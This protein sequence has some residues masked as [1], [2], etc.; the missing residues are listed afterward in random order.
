[1][2]ER[3]VNMYI[4]GMDKE[5]SVTKYSNENYYHAEE[6]RLITHDGLQSGSLNSVKG[7]SIYFKIPEN[8]KIHGHGFIRN[9][10]VLFVIGENSGE[11]KI[12]YID[13]ENIELT[14][15]NYLNDEQLTINNP[16]LKFKGDLNFSTEHPI[17]STVGRY[18]TPDVQKVYWTDGY[19]NVRYANLADNIYSYNDAR[20]FDF[21]PDVTFNPV[22]L[23]S[24]GSGDLKNGVVQYAYQFYNV[25]GSESTFSPA[26]NMIDLS[27][28]SITN[29]NSRLYKGGDIGESSGKSVSIIIDVNT[30]EREKFDRIR[31]VRIHHEDINLLPIIDIVSEQSLRETVLFTDNGG[32]SLETIPVEFFRETLNLFKA[33]D[34]AVKNNYLFAG[35]IQEDYFD[36]EDF[37][38]RAYRFKTGSGTYVNINNLGV[39]SDTK[40]IFDRPIVYR[41]TTGTGATP[42]TGELWFYES[43]KLYFMA[44]IDGDALSSTVDLEAHS[45]ETAVANTSVTDVITYDNGYIKFGGRSVYSEHEITS[46]PNVTMPA[47]WDTDPAVE[48]IHT[49]LLTVGEEELIIA[50]GESLSGV[51]STHDA[52][53]PYNLI[54]AEESYIYQSDGTTLGGEGPNIKYEFKT[55]DILIDESDDPYFFFAELEGTEENPSYSNYASPYIKSKYVGYQRDEIYSFALIGFDIKGRQSFAQWI[56]D[57]RMPKSTDTGFELTYESAGNVYAKVLYLEFEVNN[58]PSEVI[59]YQIVRCL[60]TRGDRTVLD[61]GLMAS[62]GTPYI[63]NEVDETLDRFR[64]RF[65]NELQTQEVATDVHEDNRLYEYI[66]PE[67]NFNKDNINLTTDFIDITEYADLI[68][69]YEDSHILYFTDGANNPQGFQVNKLNT[70]SPSTLEG[71]HRSLDDIKLFSTSFNTEEFIRL[72]G[73]PLKNQVMTYSIQPDSNVGEDS[74]YKGTTLVFRTSEVIPSTDR[75][76]RKV[77]KISRKRSIYPYGGRS[78]NSRTNRTYIPCSSLIS[79]SN[80]LPIDVFGGDT[81]I[82]YFDYLRIIWNG[83]R[84]ASVRFGQTVYFPIESTI[85]TNLRLDN[86]FNKVYNGVR[87]IGDS[88]TIEPDQLYI[89]IKE[90]AG[91]HLTRVSDT[92]DNPYYIQSRDLYQYNSIY[93]KPN[94]VKEYISKPFDFDILK[95]LEYDCRI[96]NSD[97]KINGEMTDSWVKMRFNNIIEVDTN[98]GGLVAIENYGNN[99]IFFQPNSIG[100]LSVEEKELTQSTT[101]GTLTLGIGGV[102]NRYDYITTLDGCKDKRSILQSRAGLYFYDRNKNTFNRLA[103]NVEQVSKILGMQPF[104]KEKV[105]NPASGMISGYNEEYNEIYLTYVDPTNGFTLVADAL[106]NT[107]TD[108]RKFIPERYIFR[109]NLLLSTGDSQDVDKH[110]IGD[111]STYYGTTY[112]SKLTLIINPGG[113]V[114]CRYDVL[115]F[116]TDVLDQ[117]G[118]TLQK[119]F[120]SLRAYNSY[121]DTGT[122]DLTSHRGL[123]RRMRTWRFNRLRDNHTN[124]PSLKDTYL[125]IDLEFDNNGTDTIR[126]DDTITMFTPLRIH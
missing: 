119:T 45:N 102:L 113:N 47:G 24:L 23:S 41:T 10:L 35:G 67:T 98:Y 22:L 95:T 107:F 81:Y 108:I 6:L 18:E 66:T 11:D 124:K 90:T 112:P 27:P 48:S 93:S 43:G 117:Y 70:Y 83:D 72:D 99:L 101:S 42:T 56:G 109:N 28:E 2:S 49:K 61:T 4:K 97:K 78:Y 54:E 104:F 79:S 125:M 40:V 80:T 82:D 58:L 12:Y 17:L 123:K 69:T 1:M 25:R 65:S 30:E 73:I 20:R 33:K 59:S 31:I 29:A 114:M 19:N 115:N 39:V 94:N 51:P 116:L 36:L 44:P 13:L 9:K 62:I 60:R 55:H 32:F 74:N 92:L 26:S 118:D 100:I 8:G 5:T 68:G 121:Q 76:D 34:L 63:E 96:S 88:Q 52:I 126:I 110:N 15:D 87:R 105:T 85:N 57:I 21:L 89:A 71:T 53:C 120:T 50:G 7:S 91:V 122:I 106:S 75:G 14:N 38:A 86:H 64:L 37:D 84:P 46:D 16:I 111:I 103:E 3:H 77:W